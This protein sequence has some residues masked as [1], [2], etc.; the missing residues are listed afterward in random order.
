MRALA[1]YVMRGR[2]QAALVAAFTIGSVLLAWIGA[3]V[4]ALVTLRKGSSEGS[5][6]LLWALIP[7]LVL[8]MWGDTGPV[9]TL[10]G[11]AL[12][13]M[14]LRNSASWSFALVAATASG[15]ITGFLLL[16]LGHGYLEEI[17]GL[18]TEVIE[19]INS[20]AV[21]QGQGPI[22]VPSAAVIAGL[23]GLSNA[24]TVVMCLILGRW[25]QSMLYNPGGFKLEFH[26]LR[27]PPMLTILLITV[28]LLL[29]AMGPDYVL[30]ASI[31]AVPLAF[32]G[33]GLVHGLV[34]KRKQ[35]GNVLVFFYIALFLLHPLKALL[36][37]AAVIDS[38]VNFRARIAA[39]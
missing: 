18:F 6:V 4:V 20:Q 3:A 13:A 1:D 2:T 10:I 36:I 25:W 7:A 15:L 35:K 30:W 29:A 14:V 8:A 31:P 22:G 17:L 28:G 34:A 33:L 5:Q 38:W 39:R 24:F 11:V 12:A 21:E 27:L 16:S 19:Q 23:L 37:V 32:A 26:Q 9:T